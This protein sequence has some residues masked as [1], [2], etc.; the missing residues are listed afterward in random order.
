MG[1]CPERIVAEVESVL[2]GHYKSGR[3][4]ELWDGNTAERIVAVL[5]TDVTHRHTILRL[6][7]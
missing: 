4:P 6:S 2:N 5:K 1:V 3:L 7:F